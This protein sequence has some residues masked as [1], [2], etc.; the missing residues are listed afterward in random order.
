MHLAVALGTP[1]VAMFGPT[2][3]SKLLPPMSKFKAVRDKPLSEVPR[4][5]QDGLGVKVE[6]QIV[7]QAVINQLHDIKAGKNSQAQVR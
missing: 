4:Q 6:P 7:Y 3:E 1:V 2:D 5:M